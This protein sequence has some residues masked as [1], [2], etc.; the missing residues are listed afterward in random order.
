MA[1]KAKLEITC[2]LI[3]RPWIGW[4]FSIFMKLWHGLKWCILGYTHLLSSKHLELE[5]PVFEFKKSSKKTKKKM[6]FIFNFLSIFHQ[7]LKL[8]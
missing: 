7:Q 2:S 6:I 3:G 1:P 4:Q 5:A 8:E